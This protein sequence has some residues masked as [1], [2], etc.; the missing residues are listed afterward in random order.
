MLYIAITVLV[1]AAPDAT[2][3]CW[4]RGWLPLEELVCILDFFFSSWGAEL[5]Q[6]SMEGR[7]RVKSM[8]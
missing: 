2:W 8:E 5:D 3:T 4:F 1:L 6:G 7:E